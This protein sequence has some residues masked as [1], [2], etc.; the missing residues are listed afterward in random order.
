MPLVTEVECC[1][2]V[3]LLFV[4]LL[5][6]FIFVGFVIFLLL[7]FVFKHVTI[8]KVINSFLTTL[9]LLYLQFPHGRPVD[10]LC[11]TGTR[12]EFKF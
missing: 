11:F 12:A 8:L 2:F 7:C 10:R 3:G 5:C 6:V 4:C 9:I 1:S